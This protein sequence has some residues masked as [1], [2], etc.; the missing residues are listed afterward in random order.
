MYNNVE[1]R[2]MDFDDAVESVYRAL[3]PQQETTATPLL[4]LL[5]G[6]PGTGKS[7]LARKIA[8]ELPC[9]IVE[10]DLARK[11]LTGGNPDYTPAESAF[12]HRVSRQVI[13]RLLRRGHRVIHDAT[14][15]AEWHREQ[16]YRLTTR[17]HSKLVIVRTIAPEAV[18]RERLAQ[19]F[20][21]RDPSDL[22]DADWNVHEQLQAEHEPVRRPHLVIDTSGDMQQA[23]RKILRALKDL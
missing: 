14:N 18:V 12:I 7:H 2:K 13:E 6:L 5:S 10:S 4:L 11:I 23:V 17:T 15:L 20:T 22:S 16:V 8:E 19:R 1:M 3:P 9:V 21:N